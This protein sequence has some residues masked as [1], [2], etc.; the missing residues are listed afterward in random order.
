VDA[1]KDKEVRDL[2]AAALDGTLTDAQAERLGA[3][4]R[5]LLKLALLAAAKRIA[6]Q[7]EKIAEQDAEITALQAKLGAAAKVDPATPSG[8]RPIYT[9]PTR[10]QRNGAPGAKVGHAGTRRPTPQ[11]IDERKE[12]RL[13]RCP[14]CGGRLRRCK[15]TRT[16]TIEDILE[17]L[18]TVVTEHTIHR[19]WCPTCRRHVE[20]VVPDAL[21]NAAVGHRTVALSSWLHYGVGV[22]I[23]QAR[24]LLAGQFQTRLSAGGLVA[25]WRRLATVLE[26]WYARIGDEARASAVLHA[27]ETGWRMNGRTWWLWCFANPRVCYYLLD[28]SRGSPA[29]EKFFVEAFDGVLITDFWPAYNA[30][31]TERQ[32][33]LVH[34]LRELEKVDE[35]NVSGE[36]QAFAKKLRRLVRDA[37]RLR[38]RSDFD[39]R[40][41]A[42]RVGRIDRRLMALAGAE[43]VDAD[44]T[45]LAKRLNRHI[46]DLFTFLDYPDVPF[47][48]NLAERMIRPAVVLR[49]VSQSNRSERG[50]A[51]QAVLMSIYRTLKLRGHDPLATIVSASR[52]YLATGQLPTLPV[53]SVADG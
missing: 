18:R 23:S 30:F 19:D 33:C 11:R 50:A 6:E 10:P 2:L 17:D 43:Y 5:H 1:A 29:L 52:S 53:E 31:A 16:R 42:S 34:L 48:N 20:P 51:V 38:K 21:P 9:K 45:R 41:H 25:T 40:K 12:H 7:N 22:S 13:S 35:H 14:C 4:D 15:R 27:D 39:R 44:A 46:D 8:Q 49:K 32:C 36:W 3:I 28:P 47:E 26:P 24:E 37:I